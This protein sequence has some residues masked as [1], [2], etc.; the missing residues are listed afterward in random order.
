MKKI[1]VRTPWQ[2]LPTDFEV[3]DWEGFVYLIENQ[4]TKQR[5]IG[6]KYLYSKR[7]LKVKG[8]KRRKLRVT[9]SDWEYYKSSSNDVKA[10]IKEYGLKNFTFEILSLHKTRAETNYTEV[11][12]QFS[13]DVLSSLLPNGEFEYYNHCILNRYYRK[14]IKEEPIKC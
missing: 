12:E 2:G 1:K 4:L 5:Y 7:R 6:R 10:D 8:K 11:K 13:R 9:E 14:R 3:S